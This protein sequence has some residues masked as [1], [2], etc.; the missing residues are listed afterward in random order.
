M[1]P[2]FVAS[3][4]SIHL[5]SPRASMQLGL[6]SVAYLREYFTAQARH[7]T[8]L[9]GMLAPAKREAEFPEMPCCLNVSCWHK[10]AIA[11]TLTACLRQRERV[12]RL[13]IAAWRQTTQRSRKYAAQPLQRG[14]LVRLYIMPL[15]HICASVKKDFISGNAAGFSL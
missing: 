4:Y 14:V 1:A 2:A 11:Q 13:S 12:K 9:C 8:N 10:H 6:R 7:R 15:W 5:S 3:L